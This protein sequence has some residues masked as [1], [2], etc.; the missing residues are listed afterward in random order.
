MSEA[1][2][3][4]TTTAIDIIKKLLESG[5]ATSPYLRV[6]IKGGGC[7]GMAY[8]IGFDEKASDDELFEIAGIPVIMKKAHGMYLLGMEIDYQQAEDTRG[9]VF[10]KK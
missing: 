8:M 1:P 5:Q 2:L 6:G 3:E 7:S 4:L 10:R 9:F